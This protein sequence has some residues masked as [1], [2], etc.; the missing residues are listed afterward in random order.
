M[1]RFIFGISYGFEEVFVS[2]DTAAVLM[3]EINSF[4]FLHCC[5]PIVWRIVRFLAYLGIRH[6]W[7]AGLP[8]FG[9]IFFLRHK[10]V[11]AAYLYLNTPDARTLLDGM[12]IAEEPNVERG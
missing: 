6:T 7:N 11:H 5:V 3:K 8:A 10:V 12:V 2:I 4:G 1:L 9:L